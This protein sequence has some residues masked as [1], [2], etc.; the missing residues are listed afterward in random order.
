MCSWCE[1]FQFVHTI[2]EKNATPEQGRKALQA[3]LRSMPM[4]W[5]LALAWMNLDLLAFYLAK[6]MIL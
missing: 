2:W 4:G 5:W 6:R 3:R 1:E